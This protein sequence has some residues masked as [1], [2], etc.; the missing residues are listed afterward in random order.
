MK[1]IFSGTFPALMEFLA[2]H[3]AVEVKFDAAYTI[4]LS[5]RCTATP[6]PWDPALL[7]LGASVNGEGMCHIGYSRLPKPAA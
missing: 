6:A 4:N 1:E 2:R 7:E 3:G 5:A